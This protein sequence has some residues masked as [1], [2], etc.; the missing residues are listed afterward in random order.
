MLSTFRG[1]LILL[2][3]AVLAIL[4]AGLTIASIVVTER[5]SI[6]RVDRD[7][8]NQI[9]RPRPPRDRPVGVPAEQ[10]GGPPPRPPFGPGSFVAEVGGEV[11]PGILS[12]E[13]LEAARQGNVADIRTVDSQGRRFRVITMKI[14]LPEGPRLVQVS[15]DLDDVELVRKRQ[16][17][18]ALLFAP[19]ALALAGIAGYFL[20][21]RA[22]KGLSAMATAV[23][24]IDVERLDSHLPPAKDLEFQQVS[25][26][27]NDLIDRLNL[28]VKARES[29]YKDLERAYESQKRFAADAS[30][31]LRTP[32]SRIKLVASSSLAQGLPEAELKE[33]LV[34][35]DADVDTLSQLITDLL[36]LAR[37]DN[38]QLTPLCSEIDVVLEVEAI[39]SK[40]DGDI[41]YQH[42]GAPTSN[43]DL[44][45]VK[46]VLTNLVTNAVRHSGDEPVK[47]QTRTLPDG[48]QL[49]VID[50]GE[51]IP[52]EHID[53]IKDRFYRV[54][55]ARNREV[56][57]TGLGLAIVDS[58]VKAHG[59]DLKIASE[60]GSGTTVV[61]T[62]RSS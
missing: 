13:S 40:L 28:N 16:T 30:H 6:A 22:T 48:L 3:I 35:I 50:K 44:R 23:S 2:N 58:L 27:F 53:R 51:G 60:L 56:G 57:G 21:A 47:V 54:D 25:S 8:N 49:M 31:E 61:A 46:R 43:V 14:D 5:Q 45:F 26:A 17:E 20:A 39:V 52:P 24:E 33:A 34:A 36:D 29:A 15:R 38:A 32:L 42:E 1:K 59:G 9:L 18:T 12:P 62:F 11:P 10:I 55:S 37:A 41:E 4:V 19:I 7:L